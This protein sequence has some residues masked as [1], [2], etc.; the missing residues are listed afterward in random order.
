MMLIIDNILSAITYLAAAFLLFYIGKLV[1]QLFNRQINMKDELVEKDNFA[2]A[3]AHAG[4]FV[5]LLLAIG[6]AIIGPSHGLVN[7]LIDIFLYGIIAIVLL[8]VSLFINDKVILRKFSLTKEII[9]D[10]NEGIGVVQAANAIATG[11]IIMGAVSGEGGGI[12]TA[13][14]F[15]AI[16]QVVM[17]ITTR[18]YNWIT[19]YDIHDHLEKDNVAIG[20]GY[21][22]ALVALG[23]LIRFGLMDDFE[24][25]TIT[26]SNVGIE[27]VLGLILLPVV[28]FLTDKILL[29]GQKLTD[30]LTQDKPNLGA[31]LI[32]AF[33]Y[34]GGSVLIT[35]CI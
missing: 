18:V 23:N 29:P 11:L 24:S 30:E 9:T 28:R 17:I 10:R 1:Y 31:G 27:V 2:F 20:I 25:W 22:G 15:W 16:G 4:Y 33:A 5:G 34:I 6:S 32:E 13:L 8:N 19:P 12:I 35:W 14:V 21:A 7:D 3:I 26:L